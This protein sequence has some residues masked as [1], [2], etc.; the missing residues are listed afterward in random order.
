MTT[1]HANDAIRDAATDWSDDIKNTMLRV[2]DWLSEAGHAAAVAKRY[3]RM[4]DSL[5]EWLE[6]DLSLSSDGHGLED[7]IRQAEN[8]LDH[9]LRPLR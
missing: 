8:V 2:S 7:V 9:R 1:T 3:E 4:V 6:E 5:Y